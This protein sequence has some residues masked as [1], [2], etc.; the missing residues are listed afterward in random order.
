MDSDIK[1]E[2]L[3][4][5]WLDHMKFFYDFCDLWFPMSDRMYPLGSVFLLYCSVTEVKTG[6][7]IEDIKW[8]DTWNNYSYQFTFTW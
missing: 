7:S 1:S 4:K 5:V 6:P 2:F 8:Y 3:S